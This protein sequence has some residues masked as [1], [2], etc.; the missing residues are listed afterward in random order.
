MGLHHAKRYSGLCCICLL[1]LWYHHD[2]CPPE[3]VG[4]FL[5]LLHQIIHNNLARYMQMVYGGIGALIF[6]VYLVYDTQ[7]L[8]YNTY[9]SGFSN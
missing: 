9:S 6:S 3:Q 4:I 5:A 1:H 2:L 8:T 7:V